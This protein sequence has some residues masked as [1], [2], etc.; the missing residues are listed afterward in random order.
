M[1]RSFRC[2]TPPARYPACR[3]VVQDS[4][5]Q[6]RQQRAS[7][8]H[9]PAYSV[10][11]SARAATAGT[12]NAA[13]RPGWSGGREPSW[14]ITRRS[15]QPRP[16]ARAQ[17]QPLTCAYLHTPAALCLPHRAAQARSRE[18][19]ADAASSGGGGGEGDHNPR[20]QHAAG[21]LLLRCGVDAHVPPVRTERSTAESLRVRADTT[22]SRGPSTPGVNRYRWR[23]QRRH[24]AVGLLLP[25]PVS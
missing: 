16:T 8:A 10:P 21:P 3:G 9:R 23:R 6:A 12:R 20:F 11:L 5:Q 24:A 14:H 22:E 4:G 19:Q 17:C 1:S 7:S 15:R 18:R 25:E 2:F 13:G